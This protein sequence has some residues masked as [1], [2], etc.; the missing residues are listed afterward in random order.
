[1]YCVLRAHDLWLNVSFESEFEAGR[2]PFDII[3]FPFMVTVYIT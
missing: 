3:I 2:V 1:M